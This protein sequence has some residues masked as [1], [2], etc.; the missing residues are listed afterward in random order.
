MASVGSGVYS[1]LAA[2]LIKILEKDNKEFLTIPATLGFTK[3]EVNFLEDPS[4]SGL[5]LQ[6]I[7][8]YWGSFSRTM[9]FLIPDSRMWKPDPTKYLW[10]EINSILN[11][12]VCATSNLTPDEETKLKNAE[13]F[14]TDVSVEGNGD[15]IR[16]PSQAAK[17]YNMYKDE[18]DRQNMIYSNEL[19]IFQNSDSSDEQV[20]ENWINREKELQENI[21]QALKNWFTLGYKKEFENEIQ[22]YVLLVQKK[23][24]LQYIDDY[25]SQMQSYVPEDNLSGDYY[26]TVYNPIDSFQSDNGWMTLTVLRDEIA[27]LINDVPELKD[28][29]SEGDVE[30]INVISAELKIINILRPWMKPE[31]FETRYW[32]TAD[33]KIICD[34]NIP[35]SGAI[36]AYI[37]GMIVIK[38]L[39]LKREIEPNSGTPPHTHDHHTGIIVVDENLLNLL[40]PLVGPNE[41]PNVT[42]IDPTI[43]LDNSRVTVLTRNLSR[44]HLLHDNILTDNAVGTLPSSFVDTV[45]N[46]KY[47]QLHVDEYDLDGFRVLAFICKKNPKCPNPN[48]YLVW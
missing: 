30:K 46:K 10:S 12:V 20:K 44:I 40:H 33:N 18:W 27:S 9:N 42:E 21:N 14:L 4:S 39:T 34:G 28:F 31:F 26:P 24:P 32:K 36:P 17:L 19:H 13:D 29:F 25:I 8:A 16:V 1:V 35:G 48:E 22:T 11:N 47:G 6:Q 3:E 23:F 45:E 43:P 37:T 38:K 2:K 15:Q 41:Q 7:Y 5:S